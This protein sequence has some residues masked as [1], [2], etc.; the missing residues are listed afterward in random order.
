MPAPTNELKSA[1]RAGEMQIGI[2][3]GLTSPAVAE[4]AGAA[5]FDWCLIDGEHG[6][7]DLPLIVS[8]LRA[9]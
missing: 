3:L 5:C 8:Q 4:M 1:I 6:P 7:N 9:L 2:W